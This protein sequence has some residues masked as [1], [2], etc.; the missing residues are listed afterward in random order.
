MTDVRFRSDMTV[1]LVDAMASDASVVRAARVSTKGAESRDAQADAGLIR[2]LMKNRHGS[3]FEHAVFTFYVEA[4]I[5]VFREL[6]RHRIASYNEESARYRELEPV[7]YVPAG[8]RPL[9]QVGKAGE[10]RFEPG[11]RAQHFDTVETL[12]MTSRAAYNLYQVM[13]ADGIAREVARM[14]LPVSIYSSAYVT[15]NARSLMNLL[16]LRTKREGS[17]FPSYP[18]R[19]IELVA[20]G[21]ERHFAR[22]MLATYAAFDEA[23]RVAP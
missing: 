16:S 12:K 19:E 10:Y 20:E 14:S 18:Q 9:V 4:P 8:D 2:Y 11:T 7:F 22:L 6:M 13:L 15:I 23:G 1:E 5:F 3:P 17:S 21:F